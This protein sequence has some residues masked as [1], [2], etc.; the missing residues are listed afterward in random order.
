MTEAC[1]LRSWFSNRGIVITWSLRADD[2][3]WWNSVELAYFSVGWEDNSV[4]V[5][6]STG[7][8]DNTV[9]L[10]YTYSQ[11][12]SQ[13]RWYVCMLHCGWSNSCRLWVTR[14]EA[15][16]MSIITN[17][18]VHTTTCLICSEFFHTKP[19]LGGPGPRPPTNRG[20]PAKPIQFYFSLMIDAYETTI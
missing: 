16:I 1:I 20:P 13:W 11:L 9:R 3:S 14:C 15:S 10:R 12:A 17:I 19:D 6:E 5:N 2:T 7:A 8:P 4:S 18:N